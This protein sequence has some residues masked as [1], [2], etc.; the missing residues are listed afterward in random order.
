MIDLIKAERLLW[1]YLNVALPKSDIGAMDYDSESLGL[2]GWQCSDPNIALVA[3]ARPI[4]QAL[5]QCTPRQQRVLTLA[6][7]EQAWRYAPG[8]RAGAIDNDAQR[9]QSK[10]FQLLAELCEVYGDKLAPLIWHYK[11][12]GEVGRKR[13]WAESTLR[14]ALVGFARVYR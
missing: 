12:S 4:R 7:S 9:P 13:I 14:A 5:R 2:P 3:R 1:W 6:L 10:R 11:P 8:R